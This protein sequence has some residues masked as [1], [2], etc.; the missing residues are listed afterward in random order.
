MTSRAYH[1][2]NERM[3][4]VEE[5]ANVTFDEFWNEEVVQNID[6]VDEAFPIPTSP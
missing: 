5:S 2:F 4:V 1:V 3:F 6:G